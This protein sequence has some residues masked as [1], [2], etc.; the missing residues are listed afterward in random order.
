MPAD[1]NVTNP[2][3]SGSVFT[4]LQIPKTIEG[5]RHKILPV[6]GVQWHP[7]RMCFS[8]KRKDTVDGKILF[9]YF[10]KMCL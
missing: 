6:F 2:W 10:I 3:I 5:I 9:E 1:R 8:K 4:K 7:E